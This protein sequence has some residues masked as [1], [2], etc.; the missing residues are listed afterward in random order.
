[1]YNYQKPDNYTYFDNFKRNILFIFFNFLS[2][3]AGL[4]K[5]RVV[6]S[7]LF[8]SI[9]TLPIYENKTNWN[10]LSQSQYVTDC[11]KWFKFCFFKV[12]VSYTTDN[13]YRFIAIT[14]SVGLIQRTIIFRKLGTSKIE[15]RRAKI[16]IGGY[17]FS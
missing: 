3:F 10:H 9:N 13:I 4:M 17:K 2:F 15:K 7:V 1:M 11:D 8:P 5:C 14:F 12:S 16:Q 6:F